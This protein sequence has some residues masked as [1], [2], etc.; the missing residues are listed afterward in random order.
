MYV[1][2]HQIWDS[3]EALPVHQ[4]LIRAN[5]PLLPRGVFP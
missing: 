4:G 3:H 5:D 2:A 1:V